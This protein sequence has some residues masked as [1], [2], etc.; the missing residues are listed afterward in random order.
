M[1]SLEKLREE[2]TEVMEY[3]AKQDKKRYVAVLGRVIALIILL[4][5]FT[6]GGTDEDEN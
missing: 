2:V 5:Q 6:G 1:S 4:E 3:L